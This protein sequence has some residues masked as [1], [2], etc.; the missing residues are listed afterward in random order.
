MMS[1][2]SPAPAC[3]SR[4]SRAKRTNNACL[5]C[6]DRKVKCSGTCPCTACSRHHVECLFEPGEKKVL[7]SE[8]SVLKFMHTHLL[9]CV[10]QIFGR[11]EAEK[12][13]R[14]SSP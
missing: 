7:V 11:S 1:D 14:E 3:S 12:R 13:R 8:K 9:T 6:R 10:V 2:Q 5:R 4:R